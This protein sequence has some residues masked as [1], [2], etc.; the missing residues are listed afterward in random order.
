MLLRC[1]AKEVG[2]TSQIG[3]DDAVTAASHRIGKGNLER[4][5]IAATVKGPL[6][7]DPAA[8]RGLPLDTLEFY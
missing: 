1:E 3:R 5:R 4:P 8:V 2:L 7:I 6:F